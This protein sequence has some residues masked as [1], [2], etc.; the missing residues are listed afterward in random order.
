MQ[1]FA[2]IIQKIEMIFTRPGQDSSLAKMFNNGEESCMYSSK[3]VARI[4]QK[5]CKNYP[6][7]LQESSKIQTSF[8]QDLAAIFQELSMNHASIIQEL[9]KSHVV[10]I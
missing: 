10:L 4:I 5:S 8:L 3:I 2:R 6:R 9:R 7:I 1:Y